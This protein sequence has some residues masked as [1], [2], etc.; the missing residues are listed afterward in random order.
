MIYMDTSNDRRFSGLVTPLV[1]LI[2]LGILIT[3][4]LI[5][6]FLDQRSVFHF[7]LE[8]SLVF[9]SAVAA[10][11]LWKRIRVEREL[12][13]QEQVE[14]QKQHEELQITSESWRKKAEH[15]HEKNK[16]LV[17]GLAEAIDQQLVSWELSSAESEVALL[18]LKGLALKEI[19][20]IR[21]VSE[22]T[23]REQARAIYRKA[24]LANRNEFAAFFLEDLLLPRSHPPKRK[25]TPEVELAIPQTTE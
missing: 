8:L 19:A 20:D 18:L 13:Y 14:L 21:E 15:W 24:G 4:D 6:D 2:M 11:I 16:S 12:L 17:E 3:F 9:S 10:W 7:F 25:P 5:A 22:R 23:V 1:V